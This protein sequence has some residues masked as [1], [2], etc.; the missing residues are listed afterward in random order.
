MLGIFASAYYSAA[1][2]SDFELISTI[3][4]GAGGAASVSFTSIPST[5]KHLQVR[6]VVRGN[7]GAA[8]DSSLLRFNSDSGSNYTYHNLSGN[9]ATAGSAG[10]APYSAIR[11]PECPGDTA[12]AGMFG[13][14]VADVLDYAST[15]KYKTTRV[16]GG[17]D[18]NGSGQVEVDS[19]VWMN[20]AAI[21]TM[22]VVPVFGTLLAQ[23]STFSL[24]G[25]K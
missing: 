22:T 20:S 6:G 19:G 25:V 1:A 13:V 7:A 11:F 2:T 17:N 5:Y 16:L 15:T 10:I 18:R 3:T 12:T 4:V 14:V 23:Y 8:T 9:G 24:Y 21:T